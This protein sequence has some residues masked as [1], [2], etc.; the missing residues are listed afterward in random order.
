VEAIVRFF[1]QR[2]EISTYHMWVPSSTVATLWPDVCHQ[3]RSTLSAY[4]LLGA[5]ESN[6]ASRPATMIAGIIQMIHIPDSIHFPTPLRPHT[7]SIKSCPY[8]SSKAHPYK[9]VS[10]HRTPSGLNP[11]RS[12]NPSSH[13]PRERFGEKLLT[14]LE[15]DDTNVGTCWST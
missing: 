8:K 9:Y 1:Q 12:E 3:V 2:R 7:G 6:R 13:P 5:E 4:T 14:Q 15:G 11:T 10:Q